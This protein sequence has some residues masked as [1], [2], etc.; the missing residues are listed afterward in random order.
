MSPTQDI[1]DQ[2]TDKL[3]LAVDKVAPIAENVIREYTAAAQVELVV[4]IGFL[5]ATVACMAGALI[6]VLRSFRATPLWENDR[7]ASK[8]I[9]GLIV[10]V[11]SFVSMLIQTSDVCSAW[12][13]T[14]APTYYVLKS[15]VGG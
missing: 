10:L 9:F 8:G 11:V 1:I 2:I 12:K 15:L 13:Q 6:V 4:S 14:V 3:G 7:D 5:L